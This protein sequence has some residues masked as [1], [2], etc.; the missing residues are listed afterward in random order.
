MKKKIII[1][2]EEDGI[3]SSFFFRIAKKIINTKNYDLAYKF[4]PNNNQNLN[5]LN[6]CKRHKIK[7]FHK[8]TFEKLA[9]K[10]NIYAIIATNSTALLNA[11]YF[12]IFPICI[13][14][15][16]SLNYY[17]KEK[18]VFPLKM[19]TNI[20]QQLRNIFNNKKKL[21]NIKKK[22]W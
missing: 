11:S 14:S 17:F 2:L 8:D 10:L 22:L 12:Q 1:F 3:P 7:T 18:I 4:R 19:D 20:L 13:K 21:N 16:F 5:I 9:S 6:Y 15:K